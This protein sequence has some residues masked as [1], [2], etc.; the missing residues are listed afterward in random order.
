MTTIA[1]VALDPARPETWLDQGFER[2]YELSWRD[3]LDIQVAAMKLRFE[4]LGTAVA[5]LERLAKKEGV[6]SV[7]SIEDVLPLL[8]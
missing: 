7:E 3:C 2:L 5:A 4:Q 1:H 6:T 8:C